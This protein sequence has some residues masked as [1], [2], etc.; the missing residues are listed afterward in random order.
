MKRCFH[1][2]AKL[3]TVALAGTTA[4]AMVAPAAAQTWLLNGS[5]FADVEAACL[6]VYSTRNDSWLIH[7]REQ[8]ET[9]LSPCSTFKIPNSLIGLD[10]GV[11]K[12]PGDTFTWDGTVHS[13][14]VLNQDHD[15]ASAVRHS[16]VWY[17][18][19]VARSVGPERMQQAL[20]R[21]GYG[22]RDISGGIDQFWL[23]SS[24][25]ISALDQIDFL[26]RLNA[27]E[28]PADPGH[29][30]TTR[31]LLLQDFAI[32]EDFR[33]TLYGKTG[34]CPMPGSDHGW[35][36]GIVER[37]EDTLVFAVN[38]IGENRWGPEARRIAIRMLQQIP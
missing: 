11:L 38:V 26:R 23:G 7:S 1:R 18:Q 10:A 36:V 32:P 30:A 27:R 3:K 35:F 20:D 16:V 21:F 5:G 12:G 17:F 28:L 6:A 14:K 25:K 13:R 15:L 37:E 4:L 22:N 2:A 33:G 24:L 31:E 19:Q 29:Q 8:C 34:S 9:P